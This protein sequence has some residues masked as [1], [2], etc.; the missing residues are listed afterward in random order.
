MNTIAAE[1]QVKRAL[2]PPFESYVDAI[3]FF[4]Q[5]RY[6]IAENKLDII[7][8]SLEHDIQQYISLDFIFIF[9]ELLT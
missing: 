3:T 6:A 1:Y 5:R 9:F 4:L 7:F 8:D 2:L